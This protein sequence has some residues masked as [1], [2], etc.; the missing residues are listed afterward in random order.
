MTILEA[1]TISLFLL[2]NANFHPQV[3]TG[4][5]PFEHINKDDVVVRK[6]L[7]RIRPERPAEGFSDAL[8]TLLAKTWLEEFEPADSPFARPNIFSVLEQLQDEEKGWSP[9]S[10]RFTSPIQI[11]RKISGVYDIFQ[12]HTR[13]WLTQLSQPRVPWILPGFWTNLS[14]EV[15]LRISRFVVRVMKST[16]KKTSVASMALSQPMVIGISWIPTGNCRPVCYQAIPF[17]PLP[18]VRSPLCAY[19]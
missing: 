6:V 16:L 1:R 13:A 8:W 3:I 14:Q 4:Q 17:L 7:T 18:L 10:E 15:V 9:T 19:E 11:E 12:G 5:R 2:R